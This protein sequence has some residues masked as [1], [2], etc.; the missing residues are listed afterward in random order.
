MFGWKL[1]DA[2]R[3]R[4]PRLSLLLVRGPTRPVSGLRTIDCGAVEENS[5]AAEPLSSW[6]SLRRGAQYET[7]RGDN[8][9]Q[10]EEAER[11]NEKERK[12]GIFPIARKAGILLIVLMAVIASTLF[13]VLGICSGSI[14][15]SR[16]SIE[17]K[18][19]QLA[20]AAAGLLTLRRDNGGHPDRG[21][22][23]PIWTLV[24]AVGLCLW[25][26]G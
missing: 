22:V 9:S 11:K 15:L 8:M 24:A 2:H 1:D 18:G 26:L 10:P 17:R 7:E 25:L 20:A 5:H 19:I 23:I 3:R 21:L 12:V 4:R 14:L 6:C 16:L 13:L